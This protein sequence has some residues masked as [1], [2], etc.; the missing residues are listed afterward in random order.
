MLTRDDMWINHS[1]MVKSFPRLPESVEDE[2]ARGQ[3][4][5]CL[6]FAA[7]RQ[8]VGEGSSGRDA[9]HD[10]AFP[11]PI[12]EYIRQQADEGEQA[13]GISAEKHQDIRGAIVAGVQRAIPGYPAAKQ[14]LQLSVW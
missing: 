13:E 3:T 1:D 4:N 7:R 6:C 5:I 14:L 2:V 10:P 9:K 12:A 11:E 8:A